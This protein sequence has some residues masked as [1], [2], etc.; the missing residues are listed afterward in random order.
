MINKITSAS[1]KRVGVPKT[2]QEQFDLLALKNP[3]IIKLKETFNLDLI[4]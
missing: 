2:V 3:A 4:L 1:N